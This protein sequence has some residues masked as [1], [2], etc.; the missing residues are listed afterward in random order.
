MITNQSEHKPFVTVTDDKDYIHQLTEKLGQGGQGAVFRTTDRNVVVKALVDLVT[1]DI[2]ADEAKYN[3]F[4]SDIDEIRILKLPEGIH[5][6][7]PVHLLKEPHCGYVMR[8]LSDMV[9][10][11]KLMISKEKDVRRFYIETGG[12]RRR[13]QLLAETARMVTRLHSLPVVYADISP[14]NIFV[15]GDVSAREVWL[16]DSDNMRHTV[17]FGKSIYTPGYGA[18]EVAKGISGNNTL[19]DVYSF[20]LLAFET[21][22]MIAPFDGE[23]VVNG[24]GW[25]NEDQDYGAMAERG[26]LPWIDDPEDDTNYSDLGIPRR[27]VLSPQLKELFQQTFSRAGRQNPAERPSMRKWY[28]VLRQAADAT[29]TCTDCGATFYVG[30]NE[31]PFCKAVRQKVCMA[32]AFD[33]YLLED[34]DGSRQEYYS[35]GPMKIL[36]TA[37]SSAVQTLESYLTRDL[38]LDDEIG[39]AIELSFGRVTKLRNVTALEMAIAHNGK[40]ERLPPNGGLYDCTALDQA[41]LHIPIDETKSRHISFRM[42]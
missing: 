3:S 12:L 2:V 25:D 21:L 33:R 11:R 7:K 1:G 28:D 34:E 37:L 31:C 19:S 17:D 4:K 39:T 23:L 38:L 24:G 6:A 40:F 15:S 22:A 18:P 8:L 32:Q 35:K 41:F 9:P 29:L 14:E 5:I 20:A 42:I 10:I 13:L 27:Y 16:I 26:E 30:H 36:D